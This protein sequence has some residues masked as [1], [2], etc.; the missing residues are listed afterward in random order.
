M[1]ARGVPVAVRV[2]LRKSAASSVAFPNSVTKCNHPGWEMG[3]IE[4]GATRH[5]N[6]PPG[7]PT[8]LD[9]TPARKTCV[10]DFGAE[11]RRLLHCGRNVW[12]GWISPRP[13]IGS[14]AA[15]LLLKWLSD[16]VSDGEK[17]A[18]ILID[19]GC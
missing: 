12:P 1:V 17:L 13:G 2:G 7:F 18:S 3:A 5:P 16:G 15:S 14:L 10:G 4:L 8:L 9:G 6:W 19:G 11:A